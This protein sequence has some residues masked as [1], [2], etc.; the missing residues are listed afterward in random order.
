MYGH[1]H[2]LLMLDVQIRE[3]VRQ[4]ICILPVHSH[5]HVLCKVFC[6]FL[7]PLSFLS[8][9]APTHRA[10]HV[11]HTCSLLLP[12]AASFR[13]PLYVCVWACAVLSWLELFLDHHAS[14]AYFFFPL[15]FSSIEAVVDSDS[16]YWPHMSSQADTKSRGCDKWN[17][18]RCL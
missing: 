14:C 12:T 10:L 1:L 17:L 15:P 2:K 11:G 5:L 9:R 4:W 6:F 7:T 18:N 16:V 13:P 3:H 8:V